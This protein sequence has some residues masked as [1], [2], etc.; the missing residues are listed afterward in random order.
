VTRRGRGTTRAGR[1]AALPDG[2]YEPPLAATAGAS[3]LVVAFHGE[4]GRRKDYL[5][6]RLPL[7]G[8]HPALAQA[9]AE[10]I[11]PGGS[12]RTHQSALTLWGT[13]V[14]FMRFLAALRDPPTT[15]A[16]LTIEH[17]DSFRAHRSA[18][19]GGVAWAE[20]R[21]ICLICR[22]PA[23]AEFLDA[24][25]RDYMLR[26]I[27]RWKQGPPKPGYSDRELNALIRAARADVAAIRNRIRAG[28]ELVAR[29]REN[30]RAVPDDDRVLAEQLANIAET[31]CVP[32]VRGFHRAAPRRDLAAHLFLT[33]PDL[34]PLMVLLVALTGRN[35]ETIKELPVEHRILEGRAIELRVVKRRRGPR[36]WHTT[37]SW[38]IGDH[39]RELH[40]PGGLYLLVHQLTA[41]GRA[42]LQAP[43]RVWAIWRNA[44][45]NAV[46]DATVGEI[47]EHSDP[48]AKSLNNVVLYNYRWVAK[49]GLTVDAV[50]DH[51][52][53]AP[54]PLDFNRLKTSIEVRH[55]RQMGG[56]LPS[57][58]RTNTAPVLFTNY[59][60]GD[61][62]VVEWA[63]DIV[64]DA[65][66]DAEQSALAAHRRALEQAGGSLRI[67]TATAKPPGTEKPT[68]D[69][70]TAGLAAEDGDETAWT[71]CVDHEHHPVSGTPC[72][73]SFLDCFHC[74]N[75]LVSTKH[76]PRLLALLDALSVRRQQL[77]EHE[78]WQRYGP[79][80][81]AIRHDILAK[82]TPAEI[83]LAA[84]A[85]PDDALL[86]LV[87][88]PWQQP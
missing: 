73:A 8:W 9:L 68:V 25:V 69:G 59:L 42:W 4:D 63:H 12:R 52:P 5:V 31:G 21:Q 61:P 70:S 79:A 20:F 30:P 46:A 78:W 10:R 32:P 19:I 58:V 75:C 37:V 47:S 81:A 44:V 33:A 74:G 45:G 28:W 34:C 66:V 24:D 65:L 36:W 3:S 77:S 27:D 38:E 87:E 40:S 85:K 53:P 67:I 60:R 49:H 56:H 76:L 43:Q 48:F 88:H 55:T 22:R 15:P 35:I 57:A 16:A 2:D 54:L 1:P 62:T 17:L 13:L 39:G 64:S 18:T 29:H 83:D 80:W 23:I 14:R 41:P 71:A 26:R 84:T 82:F 51:T 50:D 72:R 11:G 7:P 86:D 6:S